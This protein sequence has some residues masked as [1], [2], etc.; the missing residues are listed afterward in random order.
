MPDGKAIQGPDFHLDGQ[1]FSKAFEIAFLNKEGKREYAWQNTWAITTREIG[2]MVATHSD[3]RGLVLPP[4]VAPIQVV[5]IPIVDERSKDEVLNAAKGIARRLE[6]VARVKLDDRD[7]YTAGWKF[8]EWEIKGVPLRIEIG[9]RDIK[10]S[11]VI[12]VRRDT[13]EKFAAS[14]QDIE[15]VVTDTLDSVQSNL[16]SRAERFLRE[17]TRRASSIK[18]LKDLLEK[19]GG[20]IQVGW[21]GMRECED[22]IKEETGAKITNLPLQA[23]RFEKCIVCG[24]E[25]KETANVAKSY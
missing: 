24:M 2:V 20:I 15:K 5:I 12:L 19:K 10:A 1:N 4:K 6:S 18:E 11:Q 3:D 25:S 14:M 21:C 22:K 9:P 8:N 23:E 16:Y 7:Y 13:L 17:N